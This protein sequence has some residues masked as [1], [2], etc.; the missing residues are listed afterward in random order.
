M[1]TG[2]PASGYKDLVLFLA[3]AGVVA[4]LFKRLKISPILGFLGAGVVLGPSGLGALAPRLPW[5]SAITVA[6]PEDIAD[7]AE[8]GVV[9]LLFMIGLELSWERLRLMR[10]LVFGL[11]LIQLAVCAA[12]LAGLAH[13]AGAEPSAALILGAALAL[14]STA[15]VIPVMAEHHRLHAEAGRAAFSVLLFQD[16]AVA[17]IIVTLSVLAHA[18]GHGFNPRLLLA[19]APAV[20]GVAVLVGV[21]RL[22]LRPML[23][24]VARA[25]SE[26]MFLAACLLVVIGAGLISALAGL[27]MA[28]GAFIAGLLL[29]ETEYRHEVEVTIEPFKGLLLGLF[30]LSV[31]IGLDLSRLTAHPAL[32][33]GFAAALIAIKLVLTSLAARLMGLKT[34]A[35]IETG[36]TLAAG[37]EFAFV[38]LNTAM[39]AGLAPSDLGGSL[40]VAATLTMFAIPGLGAL[41]AR[42]DRIEAPAPVADPPAVDPDAPA[43][44]LVIGYGRVGR[45]V[46]DMLERHQIPWAAVDRDARNA[47]AARRKGQ[48]VYFGDAARIEFLQRLGLAGARALVVTM[49]SPEGAEAVVAAARKARPDLTIVARARDARGAQRL[50]DLGATDAI[51][52]TIEASL[53]LSEAVLV[54]IGVPM[55]LVIASVHEMRDDYR[56]QLNRPDAL[57]ARVRRARDALK[58]RQARF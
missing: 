18:Q 35:A 58:G 40:L 34:R 54:D 44:V 45:L 17:P 50:Y 29:A 42:L 47:E 56:K 49:D 36:L 37:G 48:S 25:K 33:L 28:I 12:A 41:G 14:S 10:R 15:V 20:I 39:A 46:G 23:K 43:R 7:L 8:F 22:F 26:E 21:G 52:E 4:P 9:F 38:L 55:G 51:P 30:F 57:G 3:T 32:I 31:G 27:S 2:V 11:G 19:L 53:Q 13:V 5:L 16:L 1:T 6:R 24:S